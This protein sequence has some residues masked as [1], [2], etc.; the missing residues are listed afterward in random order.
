MRLIQ[1]GLKR[2]STP[3]VFTGLDMTK[4]AKFQKIAT[5]TVHLV[6]TPK[7]NAE[8][9][10]QGLGELEEELSHWYYYVKGQQDLAGYQTISIDGFTDWHEPVGTLNWY[11][12]PQNKERVLQ[13]IQEWVALKQ[14]QGFQIRVRGPM[15][16]NSRDMLVYR[17]DIV[18]NP[19]AEIPRAPEMNVTESNWW[20]V[21]LALNLRANAQGGT[22][23][24]QTMAQALMNFK[25]HL[26]NEFTQ[27]PEESG[28][29]G[30]GQA[31]MIEFGRTDE[32]MMRYVETLREMVAFGSRNGY[33]EIGWG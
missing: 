5:V 8:T 31:R 11:C 33:Q 20:A 23:P 24:L 28:G 26:I 30:T 13:L 17:L 3:G 27:D 21:L 29:P 12:K 18:K 10:N 22:L 16:S 7:Q 25:P 2:T 14:Q 32:Q 4:L 1:N 6:D 15:G 19:T 9:K